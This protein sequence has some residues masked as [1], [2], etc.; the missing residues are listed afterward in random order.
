MT[1]VARWPILAPGPGIG[2]RS[3]H[4]RYVVFLFVA[5]VLV[6]AIR[7]FA[8]GGGR[9]RSKPVPVALWPWLLVPAVIALVVAFGAGLKR[10]A[11][12]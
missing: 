10:W 9:A 11:L 12:D 1:D 6:L 7:G 4:L 8:R 3:V 2:R 5:A